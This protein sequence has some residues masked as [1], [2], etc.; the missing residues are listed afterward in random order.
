MKSKLSS[1]ATRPHMVVADLRP[2]SCFPW[3]AASMGDDDDDA[4][5]VRAKAA[6]G[7][8][9]S[10]AASGRSSERSSAS[11]RRALSDRAGRWPRLLSRENT[12]ED[13]DR[14]RYTSACTSTNTPTFISAA[15]ISGSISMAATHKAASLLP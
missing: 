9:G 4:D 3:A 10:P 8:Q 14:M 12:V 5:H 7:E 2:Q 11:M 13:C 6:T 1:L 15:C